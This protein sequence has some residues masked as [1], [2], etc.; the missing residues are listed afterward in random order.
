MAISELVNS[1]LAAPGAAPTQRLGQNRLTAAN[2]LAV[3][4]S[5][6][7][8]VVLFALSIFLVFVGTLA[9][10]DHGVWDVVNH[11]YFRVWFARVDWTTFERLVQMFYPVE[12]NLRGGFFF[13]GG[14]LIGGMLLVNLFAAHLVRFKVA[15]DGWRLRG[16]LSV[17]ALGVL[18]TALVIRT[19]MNDTLGSELSPAFCNGL[20]HALRATLA[21]FALAG[22]YLL[23]L[24]FERRRGEWYLLLVIDLLLAALAVWLFVRPDVRLDDSGLRILWQLVK[25]LAAGGILLAGCVMA[26]RKRAGIVLLHGGVALHDV[27]RAV[28]RA[29]CQRSPDENRR[30]R[31]RQFYQRRPHHRIGP[32]RPLRSGS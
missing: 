18:V 8:T 31:D 13:P 19:G 29:D 25:G 24:S 16:G 3:L 5:L 2:V 14:K 7:L 10:V 12:W 20:W 27:Q 9:Q 32:D 30:R 23:V 15:A 26:F 1:E 11:S 17:V 21:G 4:A 6:R 22:G 28:D